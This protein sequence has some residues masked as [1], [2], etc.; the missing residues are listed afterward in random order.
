VL[1]TDRPRVANDWNDVAYITARV[2][3]ANGVLCPN[4]D[5]QLTFSA[6][7]P[8]AVVAVDNGNIASHERY[9][10]LTRQVYQGQCIAIVKANAASGQVALKVTAPGLTDGTLTLEAAPARP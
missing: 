1:S 6:S 5:Q 2:V 7:G 8:G 10:A 3:D 9:Q 4:T